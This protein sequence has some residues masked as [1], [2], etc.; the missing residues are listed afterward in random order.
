MPAAAA[1][2]TTEGM[3]ILLCINVTNPVHCRRTWVRFTE[4]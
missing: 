1:Q 2:F 4:L 3:F